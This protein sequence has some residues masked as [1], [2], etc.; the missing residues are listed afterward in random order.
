MHVPVRPSPACVVRYGVN[1]GGGE[2]GRNH[3]T[4]GRSRMTIDPRV[5]VY[6]AG[7]E[8]VDFSPNR[9]ADIACTK[10]E[11]KREVLGESHEERA[12]SC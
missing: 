6:N 4:H 7:T 9:Q 12:A 8:H 5:P 3:V 2:G 11:A 10:R 1:G